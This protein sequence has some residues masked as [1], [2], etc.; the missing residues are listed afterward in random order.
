MTS[1]NSDKTLFCDICDGIFCSR[2][3]DKAVMCDLCNIS[4]HKWCLADFIE[5]SYDDYASFTSYQCDVCWE[6]KYSFL[7]TDNNVN[8]NEKHISKKY[9]KD[10]KDDSK[11]V[12]INNI[13]THLK[14]IDDIYGKKEKLICV[15]KMFD[16]LVEQAWFM[17][18]YPIFCKVAIEKINEYQEELPRAQYFKDIFT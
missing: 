11:Y 1:L 10:E 6:G 13:K 5:L 12:V 14:S 15:N 2:T 17:K 9:E 18:T 16:Y 8:F 7:G 4:K 3:S